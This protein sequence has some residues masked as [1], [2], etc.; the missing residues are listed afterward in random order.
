MTK[1][2]KVKSWQHR[3]FSWAEKIKELSKQTGHS[4]FSTWQGFTGE[5]EQTERERESDRQRGGKVLRKRECCVDGKRKNQRGEVLRKSECCVDGWTM[6]EREKGKL[7]NREKRKRDVRVKG[8][9]R[10]R[11][12]EKLVKVEL[13]R[14]RKKIGW[15]R[16]VE[17]NGGIIKND[18]SL[19]SCERECELGKH[20]EDHQRQQND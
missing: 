14:Q 10:E 20:D 8:R 19:S 17:V 2:Q 11:E 3:R 15:H 12:R 7:L 6:R 18:K 16:R 9:E 5:A 4:L 13:L 1:K